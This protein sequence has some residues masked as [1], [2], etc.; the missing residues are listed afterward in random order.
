MTV[1]GDPAPVKTCPECLSEDVPLA[2]TRCKYCGTSLSGT[3]A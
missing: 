2:A 1:F 3:M